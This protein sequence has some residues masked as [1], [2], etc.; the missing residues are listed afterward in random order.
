MASENIREIFKFE[1]SNRAIRKIF[2]KD[3]SDISFSIGVRVNEQKQ[4]RS[5]IVAHKSLLSALSPVFEA[6]FSGN[7]KESAC[8]EIS[9]AS[10]NAFDEFIQYFYSGEV[11]ITMENVG[12]VLYLAD[13]YDVPELVASCTSFLLKHVTLKDVVDCVKLACIFSL[14]ALKAKIKQI[15]AKNTAQ[16]FESEQVLRCGRDQLFEMLSIDS[17]TCPEEKLFDICIRWAQTKCREQRSDADNE[18][19]L[20]NMLG[21]CFDLIRFREMDLDE[22]H[23]RLSTYSGMF[24]K[25]EI[26]EIYS[27][28]QVGVY[29]HRYQPDI[30]FRFDE[31]T[32]PPIAH[33][34]RFNF[35]RKML[36]KSFCVPVETRDKVCGQMGAHYTGFIK[37]HAH[38]ANQNGPVLITEHAIRRATIRGVICFEFHVPPTFQPQYFY[39]IHIGCFDQCP[40]FLV[41]EQTVEGVNLEMDNY[42]NPEQALTYFAALHF[43]KCE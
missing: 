38:A 19:H 34:T 21:N 41:R 23:K 15:I 1:A 13:K 33:Y 24:T 30:V 27:N 25:E 10:Y 22:F 11:A 26:I 32:D 4:Q 9:D 3:T 14:N 29:N 37:I 35:S 17:S 39:K 5:E 20:R 31:W 12:E 6:M 42:L 28:L 43:E 40:L 36:L 16:V 2:R 8:I 18:N 7:W